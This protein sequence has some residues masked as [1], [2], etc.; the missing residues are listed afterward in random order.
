LKTVNN[1]VRCIIDYEIT[2]PHDE[3]M[4]ISAIEELMF[5]MVPIDKQ[6]I[7][8]KVYQMIYN[9]GFNGIL[10]NEDSVEGRRFANEA[11]KFYESIAKHWFET[12]N[13]KDNGK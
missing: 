12:K 5:D 7:K 2:V 1:F 4:I 6:S 10:F 13:K 11:I 3:G 8:D 9:N